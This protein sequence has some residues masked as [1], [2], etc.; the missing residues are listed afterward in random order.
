ML[1]YKVQLLPT[2][3]LFLALSI[4]FSSI[5]ASAEETA[6]TRV[7]QSSD[8]NSISKTE[9][10]VLDSDSLFGGI[11]FV[12]GMGETKT[13]SNSS[14][15]A[16]DEIE[17]EVTVT[18]NPLNSIQ[19]PTGLIFGMVFEPAKDGK[20]QKQNSNQSMVTGLSLLMGAMQANSK[21]K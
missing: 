18:T 11:D 12:K 1:H 6:Q 21:G 14:S 8:S 9:K 17:G 15:L 7:K 20:P 2:F 13:T 5:A 19:K 10:E 3:A 4:Y 16:Q